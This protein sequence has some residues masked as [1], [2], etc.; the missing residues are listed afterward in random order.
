[1]L[2]SGVGTAGRVSMAVFYRWV[3]AKP[4]RFWVA[5]AAFMIAYVTVFA[6]WLAYML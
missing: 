5:L 6:C 1:M 2:L 4:A 3:D